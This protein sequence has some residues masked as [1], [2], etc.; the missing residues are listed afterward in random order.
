MRLPA[1]L[2]LTL[3]PFA[4]MQIYSSDLFA[5]GLDGNDLVVSRATVELQIPEKSVQKT[6]ARQ[7]KLPVRKVSLKRSNMQLLSVLL[8]LKEKRL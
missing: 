3:A 8:L 1:L 4:S 2:A 5:S 7:Q 6:M